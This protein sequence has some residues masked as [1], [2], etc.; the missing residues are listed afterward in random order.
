MKTSDFDY[1]L[2]PHLI[3][4]T[5]VEPRDRSRLMVLR[6]QDGSFEHRRF[7]EILDY[8]KAGDALVCNESRVIPARLLGRKAGS[9]G[10]VEL[11]LLRRLDSGLWE[12]L[13]KP[14]RRALVGSAIEV[15]EAP[16]TI[17]GAVVDRTEHG[18][19][20]IRF[21]NEAALEQLGQVPLPPYIHAA[22]EDSE[23]YQTVFARVKGSV[24]APT[25][26]LHFTPELMARIRDKGVSIGFV[27]VHLGLGSFRL[28]QVEEPERHHLAEEYCEVSAA[29]AAQLARVR[30]KGGRI[31]GVGT[32]TV[33]A[34]EQAALAAEAEGK[35]GLISAFSGWTNLFILPG[36]RFRVVDAMVTNF[37][38]PRSTLLMLVAAFAGRDLV[39]RAYQEAIKLNYRFYS[40]GDAMVIV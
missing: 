30:A 9:G 19:R 17:T 29:L 6:R 18:G 39:L 27:T 11:L 4:Q 37:H 22:L 40:F 12:T 20:L 25:A 2:P 21:S 28:V 34:L 8:L 15:G 33:R 32:S 10:K 5:P 24:A 14:G 13:V 23:R 38:L 16:V 26:G 31:I 1:D 3:A 7:F 35:E 36:H